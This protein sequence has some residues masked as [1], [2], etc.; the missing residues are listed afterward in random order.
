MKLTLIAAL[1]GAGLLLTLGALL[2]AGKPI[3]IKGSDTMAM[4]GQGWAEAY[5]GSHPNSDISV[6]GGGSGT[7][8]TA[9]INGACDICQ[10]S[11]AMK[12]TEIAKCKDRNFV[13]VA[14]TVALDGIALAVNTDNPVTSLTLAQI[15]AIYTGRVTNWKQLGGR[16]AN[17]VVLSRENSSGTYA[18]LRES[19]LNNERYTTGA[20]MMPTTKS[21]QQEIS[22]NPRAIGY[23][24][25]A[26]FKGKR[27]VKVLPIAL[28]AGSAPVLPGDDNV[29][30][31]KYPIS[32]PLYFYTAGQPAGEVRAFV[33]FCLSD[34]GQQIAEKLGYVALSR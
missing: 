11:R 8:I 17:I 26:Y 23:G 20:L 25:E 5:L 13:P 7:G 32:R 19:V 2:A 1:T 4:L 15:K 31:K 9:L 34:R 22:N 18:Y 14:T 27:N 33:K 3:V 29:R 30:S 21:I 16:D 28:K 12:G 6:Q 24:G 10:A